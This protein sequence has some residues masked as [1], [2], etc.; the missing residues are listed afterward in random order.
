MLS[1]HGIEFLGRPSH[2][3]IKVSRD[4]L[5][6][7]KLKD[8][9]AKDTYPAI[10]QPFTCFSHQNIVEWVKTR[11][12]FG[13]TVLCVFSPTTLYTIAYIIYGFMCIST[14]DLGEPFFNFL[15]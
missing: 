5:D 2:S 4:A 1:C 11:V 9:M 12:Y 13:L 8:N 3:R 14:Q 6:G 7:H 10:E 15:K